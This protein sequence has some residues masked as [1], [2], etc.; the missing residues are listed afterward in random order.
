MSHP[1][2]TIYYCEQAFELGKKLKIKKGLSRPLSFIGLANAYKGDYTASFDY[3]TRAVAIAEEERDSVQ[4][5]FGYNNFGRLFFD[6]GDLV[7]AYNNF[8][9]ARVIFEHIDDNYGQAYVS[10]SLSNLYKSQHDYDKALTMS[11]KAV[12]IRRNMGD[13]RGTLSALMELG[14]VYQEVNDTIRAISSLY[15]ADSIAN[16]IHDAISH[17][18]ILLALS[19]ILLQQDQLKEACVK[20]DDAYEIIEA[21]ANKRLMPRGNLLL[22]KCAYE[23]GDHVKAIPYFLKVIVDGERTGNIQLQLD[24]N[25]YL[26][27]IYQHVHNGPKAIEHSNRYL[28]LKETLQNVDLTRQIE[29]LQ[30][31]LDI[32]KK[33]KE[34]ELLLANKKVNESIITQQRLQN[35][36]LIFVILFTSLLAFIQWRSSKKRKHINDKLLLQNL[37]IQK[38]R[39]EIVTQNDSLSKRNQQLNDLN[40]EKDTLM[41]IVAHDLKSPL[42]RIHGLTDIMDIDNSLKEDQKMYNGLIRDSTRAGLDLIKDLLDVHM[43]EENSIPEFASVSLGQVMTFKVEN[44][45][46]LAAVKGITI[47]LEESC[48]EPVKSDVNYISRI[49]DNLITNAIKFS[50]R[51]SVIEVGTGKAHDHFWIRIKD[52]GPGFSEKDRG[53]LFQKFKKLSAQPTAGESSNGLGL[54]I[55]KTLVDR[56]GGTITL[57]SELKKGSEFL[58]RFPAMS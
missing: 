46:Q 40:H 47:R 12:S 50:K 21:T 54:A 6:Q 15:S 36:L 29:R 33:E 17:A 51:D 53:Q 37:E 8:L 52:F 49:I 30:F 34:N 56:M 43:L 32:E 35:I 16:S 2:S 3:H 10:R 44:L 39:E 22:G 1:D 55:V 25:F 4:L 45:S 11:L 31:Q 19:E 27:K 41:S 20:A 28:I 13:A 57:E 38:Q 5:A 24:A 42:N 9:K 14:L 23:R 7:R 18:E 58:I 26:S 48:D